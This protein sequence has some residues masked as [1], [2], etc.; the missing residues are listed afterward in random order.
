MR[1]YLIMILI[2]LV[3]TSC[4][5]QAKWDGSISNIIR[6]EIDN[7]SFQSIRLFEE[8]LLCKSIIHSGKRITE[9][10]PITKLDFKCLIEL[11][12][13]LLNNSF[14]LKDTVVDNPWFACSCPRLYFF[15]ING[16]NSYRI[17]WED[18]EC[19]NLKTCLTLLNKLIPKRKRERYSIS[20]RPS[21]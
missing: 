1:K 20:P 5:S 14:M 11:Q 21:L 12:N 13:F 18:G 8:G 16:N 2:T 19:E 15:I 7:G 4:I 6:I 17:Y 3:G 9:F 10:F